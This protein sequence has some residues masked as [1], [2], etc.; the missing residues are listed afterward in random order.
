MRAV[1][2]KELG[3][4]EGLTV[5][6]V[7]TVPCGPG[8]VRVR[9]WACGVNYVD[10][11]FVQGRYQIKPAVPFTP[12]SEFSGELTEIGADVD[13]WAI[14]DRVISSIGL[15]GF[16]DEIVIDP[17]RCS[18]FPTASRSVRA[19]PCSSPTPRHGSP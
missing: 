16:A 4:P 18:G 10:A 1:L 15:G 3:E 2:C 8:E 12:G 6:H 17:A 5:E 13:G 19:P 11:L 7:P 9:I 14:G